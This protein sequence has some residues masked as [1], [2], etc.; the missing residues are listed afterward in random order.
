MARTSVATLAEAS[1]GFTLQ[2][3]TL[4]DVL[5]PVVAAHLASPAKPRALSAQEV[6]DARK[7][8]AAILAHAKEMTRATGSPAPSST[9][10][11]GVM[12]EVAAL[13]TATRGKVSKA[14]FD[15]LTKQRD[16]VL[17]ALKGL[18]D[19]A[20]HLDELP[21]ERDNANAEMAALD[22]DSYAGIA[23]LATGFRVLAATISYGLAST[24]PTDGRLRI[25]MVK[26]ANLSAEFANQFTA[27]ANA[28]HLQTGVDGVDRR[29]L[30]TGQYLR[31]SQPTAFLDAYEWHNA[32]T[33]YIDNSKDRVQVAKRLF[34][35]D[36]WARVNEVYA[37]GSG[38]VSMAFIRDDIG[39]WNLKQFSS[40]AS[41]LTAAYTKLGLD[42][43]GKVAEVPDGADAEGRLVMDGDA[44]RDPCE[45]HGPEV[46]GDTEGVQFDGRRV[47]RELGAERQGRQGEGEREDSV[48]ELH[49]LRPGPCTD[50]LRRG[51]TRPMA[52]SRRLLFP[53]SA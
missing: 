45:R 18:D 16:G 44:G 29:V 49:R 52:L 48:R 40:D 2:A 26:V 43:V 10:L 17:A 31:D 42:L 38:D 53:S 32:A 8:V 4:V 24:P 21:S 7:A 20:G 5:K 15:A 50:S 12:K 3:R 6:A 27:R 51:A 35:D 11:G 25:D 41:E 19:T 28:L 34:A 9:T 36:N 22:I 37:S 39:N 13:A 23:E 1:S 14:G 33:E 30:P 46:R 47:S